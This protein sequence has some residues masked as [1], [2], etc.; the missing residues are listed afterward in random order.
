MNGHIISFIGNGSPIKK[1]KQTN[2]KLNETLCSA[3]SNKHNICIQI[4]ILGDNIF[5]Q[6]SKSQYPL[7][8]LGNPKDNPRSSF[9]VKVKKVLYIIITGY[10]NN[11]CYSIRKNK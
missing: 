5:E 8:S 2:I 10:N 4:Y 11:F 1:S 7:H 3:Y 9:H 6:C